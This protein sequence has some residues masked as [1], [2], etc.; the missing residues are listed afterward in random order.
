MYAHGTYVY[1]K[2]LNL[3]PPQHNHDLPIYPSAH[4][5]LQWDTHYQPNDR[6]TPQIFVL[7]EDEEKLSGGDLSTI[8]LALSPTLG[9]YG[10]SGPL[11]TQ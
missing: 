5:R 2:P 4:M 8:S 3:P 6:A 1:T 9:N 7:A 11:M 10:H